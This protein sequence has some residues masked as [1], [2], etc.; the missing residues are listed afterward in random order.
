MGVVQQ[1]TSRWFGCLTIRSEWGRNTK[2]NGADITVSSFFATLNGQ[3][4][5]EDGFYI[6]GIT[7]SVRRDLFLLLF[8]F[9][10]FFFVFFSAIGFPS[11][12]GRTCCCLTDPTGAHVLHPAS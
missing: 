6:F 9:F 8:F 4:T 3:G 5:K 11:K 1:N 12:H 2:G 7:H 10:V